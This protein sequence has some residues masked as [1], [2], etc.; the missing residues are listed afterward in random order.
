MC[1]AHLLV[2]NGPKG[3]IVWYESSHGLCNIIGWKL[4]EGR[5]NNVNQWRGFL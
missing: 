5:Q 2:M 4:E 1:D 3:G